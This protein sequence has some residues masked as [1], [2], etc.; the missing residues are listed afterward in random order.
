MTYKLS[1]YHR[2][3]APPGTAET[4]FV[5]DNWKSG[6]IWVGSIRY[7]EAEIQLRAVIDFRVV[8]TVTS[9]NQSQVPSSASPE[10]AMVACA[11]T[12]VQE[13]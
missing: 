10:D 12:N 8:V 6:R 2:W 5:P 13:L 4:F 7:S 11:V 9:V 1:H 3:V